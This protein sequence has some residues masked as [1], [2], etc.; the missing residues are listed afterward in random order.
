MLIVLIVFFIFIGTQN[1]DKNNKLLYNEPFNERGEIGKLE[2][3]NKRVQGRWD[4]HS[5]SDTLDKGTNG[6]RLANSLNNQESPMK[7]SQNEDECLTCPPLDKNKRSLNAEFYDADPQPIDY[8]HQP[9]P[10][11]QG[12][13]QQL[14]DGSQADMNSMRSFS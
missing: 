8:S 10:P 12:T 9:D 5:L 3:L 14:W 13:H 6:D 4:G 2:T 7:V 11:Q 1:K